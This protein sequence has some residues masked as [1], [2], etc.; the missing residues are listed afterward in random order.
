MFDNIK[1]KAAQAMA[2]I[3]AGEADIHAKIDAAFNLGALHHALD[4]IL[5]AE[6]DVETKIMAAFDLGKKSQ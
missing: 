2:D 4:M 6:S 5:N 3:E 1:Q